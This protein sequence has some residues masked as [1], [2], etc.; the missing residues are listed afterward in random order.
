M[1][2]LCAFEANAV[3][4]CVDKSLAAGVGKEHRDSVGYLAF[5]GEES[6]IGDELF[7]GG[8]GCDAGLALEV[9]DG[10]FGYVFPFEPGADAHIEVELSSI[11][12]DLAD[13]GR[14]AKLLGIGSAADVDGTGAEVGL[15]LPFFDFH[16]P[17]FVARYVKRVDVAI[18]LGF[19]LVHGI[20]Q[21]GALAI[22][23]GEAFGELA[24]VVNAKENVPAGRIGEGADFFAKFPYFRG[25]LALEFYVL[26]FSLGN[27]FLCF[28][29]INHV[30]TIVT[31]K[32]TVFA[33][34]SCYQ[35]SSNV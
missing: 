2:I 11:V 17:D 12:E 1:D 29:L 34:H 27:Q 19:D 16:Y 14:F 5:V 18:D 3:D 33:Q 28:L 32:Y 13:I 26:A 6:E 9:A 20:P 31:H 21:S 25:N 8:V 35:L 30:S 23:Y 7:A 24:V 22:A 4:D 15:V 10:F